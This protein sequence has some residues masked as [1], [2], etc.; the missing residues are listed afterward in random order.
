MA[1]AV[2]GAI[3]MIWA[4]LICVVAIIGF[5]AISTNYNDGRTAEDKMSDALAQGALL[6]IAAISG[7]VGVVWLIVKVAL[8]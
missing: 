6:V 4:F 7:L 1:D 3:Q 5:F 8:L 2:E